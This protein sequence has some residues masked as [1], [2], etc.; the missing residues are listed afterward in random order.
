MNKIQRFKSDYQSEKLTDEQ[1]EFCNDLLDEGNRT[2]FYGLSPEQVGWLNEWSMEN[3]ETGIVEVDFDEAVRRL[4]LVI[5]ESTEE[6]VIN[7]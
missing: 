1:R 3:F 7:P 5:V 4:G 6:P 2:T